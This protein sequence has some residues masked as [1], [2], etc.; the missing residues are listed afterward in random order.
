MPVLWKIGH[1]RPY[2]F[3]GLKLNIRGRKKFHSKKKWNPNTISTGSIEHIGSLS[4]SYYFNIEGTRH[5][6]RNKTSHGNH[7]KGRTKGS[8]RLVIQSIEEVPL[9]R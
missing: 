6:A 2:C 1:T 8:E 3:E 4:K 7:A 5:M 9:R